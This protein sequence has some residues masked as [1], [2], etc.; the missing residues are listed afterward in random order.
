MRGDVRFEA[1]TATALPSGTADEDAA[2]YGLMGLGL[3]WAS[4]RLSLSSALYGGVALNGAT[5]G[6]FASA[7][8]RLEGWSG[9][10]GSA[11]GV[12]GRAYGFSVGEPFPYRNGTLRVGPALRWVGRSVAL[13]ARTEVGSGASEVELRRRADRPTRTFDEHLWNRG[14]VLEGNVR[15]SRLTAFASAGAWSS[16]GGP[17]RSVEIGLGGE[18]SGVVVR[19]DVGWWDTPLGGEWVGGLALMIPL[20]G[21]WSV[22]AAG[23]RSGPDPLTLVEAGGQGGILIGWRLASLVGAPEGALYEVSDSD[24]TGRVVAFRLDR[25]GAGRVDLIGGFT[26]WEPT[27]MSRSEGV[28]SLELTVVPG[29]HHFGFLVDGEW[30]V[31]DGLPGNV[32]DD[33]GRENATLVV[34]PVSQESGP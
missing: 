2:L 34:P 27:A 7:V 8:L 12:V 21:R 29:T 32:P 3:D 5:G 1:G 6:D 24:G 18:A 31:P 22:Q 20:G 14:A 15:G 4:D 11:L 26:G 23:G 9:G 17:F 13:E 19:G 28:W 16:A 10:R 25:S 33:W 30:Y